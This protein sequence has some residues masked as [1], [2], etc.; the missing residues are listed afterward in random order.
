MFTSAFAQAPV[1]GAPSGPDMLMQLVPFALIFV[2]AY[3]LVIRPQRKKAKQHEDLI[4]NT[5]KGDSVITTGGLIGKVTRVVDDAELEL[6]IA[7]NVKV[8]VVR[9]MISNVRSKGEPVKDQSMEVQAPRVTT[10]SKLASPP[11]KVAAPQ[12][13]EDS[14]EHDQA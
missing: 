1:P 12:P 10:K 8:R 14:S 2:I 11:P 5:R 7:P 6:E 13:S 3:F 4:K 9:S